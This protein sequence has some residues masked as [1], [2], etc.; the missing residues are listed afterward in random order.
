MAVTIRYSG[1]KKNL[2]NVL[3]A[4]YMFLLLLGA[5]GSKSDQNPKNQLWN[6]PHPH[7]SL[8]LASRIVLTV[9]CSLRRLLSVLLLFAIACGCAHAWHRLLLVVVRGRARHSPS[10]FLLLVVV[11]PLSSSVV[12]VPLSCFILLFLIVLANPV[13]KHRISIDGKTRN[14]KYKYC[15]NVLTRGVY[16]LKHHLAGTSKDIGACITVQ[17]ILQVV[18]AVAAVIAGSFRTKCSYLLLIFF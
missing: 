8:P 16:R 18:R 5:V 3:N 14:V 4:Q 7:K 12:V 13:W 15:E 17:R 10:R 11:V 2:P 6:E 9:G 1:L